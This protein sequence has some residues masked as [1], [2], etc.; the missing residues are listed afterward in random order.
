MQ[1]CA[2]DIEDIAESPDDDKGEREPIGGGAAK[3]LYD[4]R[5]VDDDPASY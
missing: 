3:V 2:E 4:L 5:R 1:D